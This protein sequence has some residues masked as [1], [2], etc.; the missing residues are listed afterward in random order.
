MMAKIFDV[1]YLGRVLLRQGCKQPFLH[2][3]QIRFHARLSRNPILDEYDHEK[4]CLDCRYS[5]E[6]I[7]ENFGKYTEEE[8]IFAACEGCQQYTW[9][10]YIVNT[11]P[12]G[13]NY[14]VNH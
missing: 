3:E 8:F 10:P 14:G 4:R 12:F 9:A 13:L 6:E 7:I 1:S 2:I 11:P 5:V